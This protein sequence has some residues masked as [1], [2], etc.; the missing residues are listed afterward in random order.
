MAD[1]NTIIRRLHEEIDQLEA[2]LTEERR[3]LDAIYEHQRECDPAEREVWYWQ[4][5]GEDHPESMVN[6][7]PVVIRA[8][9]LRA[10]MQPISEKT[11]TYE[12]EAKPV[13]IDGTPMVAAWTDGISLSSD[14]GGFTGLSRL[15]RGI[16]LIPGKHY[17]ITVEGI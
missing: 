8:K 11:F 9:D 15:E 10:L 17:R 2:Q 7:L 4:G 1:T 13:V 6:E 3:K 5:D 12:A 16:D 14:N